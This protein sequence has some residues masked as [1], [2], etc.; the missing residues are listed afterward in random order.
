MLFA[1]HCFIMHEN[2]IWSLE[3][4]LFE[5][6]KNHRQ[7][8][9][10]PGI[11]AIWKRLHFLAR[12]L[13]TLIFHWNLLYT[14]QLCVCVLCRKIRQM[15]KIYIYLPV[16]YFGNRMWERKRNRVRK[17]V[18]TWKLFQVRE[19]LF[20]YKQMNILSLWTEYHNSMHQ[21]GMIKNFTLSHSIKMMNGK[22][23]SSQHLTHVSSECFGVRFSFIFALLWSVSC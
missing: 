21:M 2:S 9:F 5:V 23:K 10:P 3:F 7:K 8:V 13:F 22:N 11:F 6:G 15:I 17:K 1:C 19:R 16:K 4:Q 12:I 18:A 20:L 14:F